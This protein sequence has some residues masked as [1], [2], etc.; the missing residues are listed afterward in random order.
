MR[1]IE[2]RL[3]EVFRQ[4]DS[5]LADITGNLV[6]AAEG[7]DVDSVYVTSAHPGEGKTTMS[8]GM[9]YG[10]EATVTQKVALVEANMRSPAFQRVFDIPDGELEAT[11]E[12]LSTCGP[13][14]RNVTATLRHEGETAATNVSLD[15]RLTAN[16]TQVWSGTR[17]IGRLEGDETVRWVQSADVGFGGSGTVLENDGYVTVWFEVGHA[18]GS[19]TLRKRVKVA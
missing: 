18:D 14:C 3:Q 5:H 7:E 12:N 19:E 9:A 15:M 16:G 11:L 8:V 4:R 17:S 2:S 1:D 13:T 6:S 10:L